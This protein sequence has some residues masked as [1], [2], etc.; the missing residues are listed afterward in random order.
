MGFVEPLVEEAG[1]DLVEAGCAEQGDLLAEA[2]CWGRSSWTA[3]WRASVFGVAGGLEQVAGEAAL[4]GT[5]A[6][7]GEEAEEGVGA[8]EVEV[9]LVEVAGLAEVLAGFIAGAAGLQDSEP[10]A[11]RGR[12]RR[13][14]MRRCLR[15]SFDWRLRA[16]GPEE[17]AMAAKRASEGPG[18]KS[19]CAKQNFVAEALTTRQPA[20]MPQGRVPRLRVWCRAAAGA[21]GARG[22]GI[23]PPLP[24]VVRCAWRCCGVK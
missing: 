5:G 19:T 15:A 14:P 6:D 4:A 22:S 17:A 13:R 7:G 20:R 12:D 9:A 11:R 2:R 1:G 24:C 23:R 18:G 16:S 8:E 10:S 21:A 3:A